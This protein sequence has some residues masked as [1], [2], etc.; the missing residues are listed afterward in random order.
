MSGERYVD[1]CIAQH[2]RFGGASVMVWAGI[3]IG[4]HTDLYFIDRGALTGVRYRDEI[5]HPIVRPFAGA[6]GD[7]FILMDDNARPHRA[8]VVN[9]YLQRET[10]VRMDWFSCSP[11]LNPIEHALDVLQR[12]ISNRPRLPENCNELIQAL[13]EEWQRIPPSHTQTLD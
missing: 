5:L 9:Q 13:N 8:L 2:D 1:S 7:D 3:S 6:I 12:A 11:D 4:G 10:I